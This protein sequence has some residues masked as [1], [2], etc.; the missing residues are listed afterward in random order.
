M[1]ASAL[2][3]QCG[4]CADQA[5][6]QVAQRMLV[7]MRVYFEKPRTT[8]GWK[9]LINDP[10]LYSEREFDMET[11]L[12]LARKLCIP[13]ADARRGDEEMVERGA[14]ECAAGRPLHRQTDAALE[15]PQLEKPGNQLLDTL[16]LGRSGHDFERP[17]QV[18]QPD[19]LGDLE[20]DRLV[21]VDPVRVA[22]D[23]RR[24]GSCRW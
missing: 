1:C 13:E 3:A 23:R 21:A 12:R 7:V 20:P 9:G 6:E 14:A 5:A 24:R 22:A 10:F 17:L 2:A 11:G 15:R 19:L 16:V 8:T 18:G 4:Q